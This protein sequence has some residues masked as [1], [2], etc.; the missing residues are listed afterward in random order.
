MTVAAPPVAPVHE[1]GMNGGAPGHHVN[2]MSLPRF[3]PIAMNPPQPIP[4]EHMMPAHHQFR[5]F[6]PPPLQEQ[7]P[8]APAPP[9]QPFQIDHIEARLRQLEHEEAARM[10]ARSHL[11]AIRKR[12]DEEF[13]R[14]TENAEAEEEEL[15]RQRKRI[16]RESM[17]LGFN[18]SLDSPPLRPTPPRRL[19]ETNAATTLAFFKQQSP[20]EP[21]P[22][23]P[24]AQAAPPHPPPQH[25]HHD[26]T[27]AT[28]IRRKQKYTIKNVEAWGERH[29][30][31][32]AH[33]PS[34]RALWKR[35]SDG[36]L[37]YLTCPVTGCGKADFV[38]LHGFMCHLTKKHKDRSLGSQ[39]RA[40]EVCGIVFDPNAP[41]PPVATVN[42]ASTEESRL[43]SGPAD[44]EGYQQEMEY[45]S[46]SDEEE[47]REVP[48]KTEASE[49]TL[50][51]PPA[52][53]PAA[54]EQIPVPRTNGSTKQSISSIIDRDP[55]DEPRGRLSSIPP[56]PAEAPIQASPD[57]KPSIKDEAEFPRPHE[58]EKENTQPKDTTEAK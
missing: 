9:G 18:A 17:G 22:I 39:S 25:I 36:S 46:A 11:L 37:V 3:H 31:P 42:R 2:T 20:P 50:P 53:M 48:V 5:P 24:P 21:R 30:R 23:P 12:E 57:Q 44:G 51:A 52:T 8:P 4:P 14:M 40:L 13:R 49:R 41:L 43:E 47:S 26:P 27:G 10:A 45:S 33:D 55:E 34:G 6:H 38:T 7:G 58:N 32:A 28:S 16:K 1:N 15:R 56:R 35:P 29:G 54:P 19:S